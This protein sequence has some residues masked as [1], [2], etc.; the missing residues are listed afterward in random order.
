MDAAAADPITISS[1][2]A[3]T[4]HFYAANVYHRQLRDKASAALSQGIPLFVTEWGTVDESGDGGVDEAETR[5]WMTFLKNYNISH[6][7][8]SLNDKAEGASALVPGASVNGGW[9]DGE[10]TPSGRLVK[11]IIQNW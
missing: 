9:S 8:W 11:E 3:Y 10:L 1:N 7:N 5:T 2:I 4:L 6:A